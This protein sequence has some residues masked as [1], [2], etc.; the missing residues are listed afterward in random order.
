MW[1][2]KHLC[3]AAFFFA[4]QNVGC[5]P[6]ARQNLTEGSVARVPGSVHQIVGNGQ[7]ESVGRL[8]LG[9]TGKPH[10]LVLFEAHGEPI[11]QGCTSKVVE[12]SIGDSSSLQDSVELWREV[13]DDLQTRVG[14]GPLPCRSKPLD[15]VIS[16]K[17]DKNIGI[18]FGPTRLKIR[19]LGQH[20]I[21]EAQGTT[22]R[23]LEGIAVPSG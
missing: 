19:K 6:S 5:A 18:A 15:V 13:V 9:M 17:R 14:I 1:A 22:I 2:G 4:G 12:P 3:L 16:T 8:E 10:D 7:V 21:G 20:R 11:R 23:I